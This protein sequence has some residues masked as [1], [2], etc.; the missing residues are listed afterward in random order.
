MAKKIL[1]IE[2][3]PAIIQMYSLKFKEKGY[4]VIEA[5]TGID[6]LTLAKKNQPDVILLDII[7]PQMDGFAVLEALKKDA[8]T[9]N[10]AVVLLTNL[11]QDTDK[12]KGEKLGAASYLIKANFTPSQVFEQIE[13]YLK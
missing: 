10:I 3:D 7:I 11:G 5:S 4:E 6:G 1:I 9:K 13:K 8:G 12:V 2:D